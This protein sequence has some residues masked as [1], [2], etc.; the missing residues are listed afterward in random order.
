MDLVCSS[1]K[2]EYFTTLLCSSLESEFEDPMVASYGS[3][4]WIWKSKRDSNFLT[5]VSNFLTS[6]LPSLSLLSFLPSIIYTCGKV[7][8]KSAILTIF[9]CTIQFIFL[10]HHSPELFSSCKAKTL[11]KQFWIPLLPATPGNHHS[12]FFLFELNYLRN[13]I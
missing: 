10:C 13:L 1:W 8:I 7:Y 5:L 6:S 12:T 3:I 11:F 4:S 9:K 2:L